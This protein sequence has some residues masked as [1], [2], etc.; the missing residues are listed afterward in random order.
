M[1][2]RIG[3]THIFCQSKTALFLHRK[4]YPLRGEIIS[5]FNNNFASVSSAL[6][7]L[8]ADL[9]GTYL[10]IASQHTSQARGLLKLFYKMRNMEP[11][12]NLLILNFK[13]Y[14]A[15]SFRII[16]RNRAYNSGF[17]F[18]DFWNNHRKTPIEHK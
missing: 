5:K 14:S 13:F 1:G 7:K 6:E 18:P 11:R 12:Y 17:V 15:I 4:G 9:T 10:Y 2:I 8:T 16:G 3:L